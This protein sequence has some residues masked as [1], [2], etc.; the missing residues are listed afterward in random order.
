MIPGSLGEG[1]FELNLRGGLRRLKQH[2]RRYFWLWIAYQTVKGLTTT[3]L[4]WVPLAMLW[5]A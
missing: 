2:C 5:R 1:V 4:I 3:T